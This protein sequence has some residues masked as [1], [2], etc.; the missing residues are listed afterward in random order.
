MLLDV[1]VD[2]LAGHAVPLEVV[3]V[4]VG[5]L[6]DVLV[7]V[8]IGVLT[9]PAVPLEVVGVL[10]GVLL[11]VLV[12]VLCSRI[13]H[14]RLLFEDCGDRSIDHLCMIDGRGRRNLPADVIFLGDVSSTKAW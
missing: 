8:L 10:V 7:D 1:L 5:V 2:V 12:D 11:D 13:R 4:L 3:G 14:V 6:L 9:G